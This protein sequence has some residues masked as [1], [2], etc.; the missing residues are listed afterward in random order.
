MSE[1]AIYTDGSCIPTNPGPGGWAAILV[2][3]EQTKELTGCTPGPTTNQRMEL[4]A[5][6]EALRALNRPC[7]ISVFTDSQYV[8]KGMTE[9]LPG[10]KS[11]GRLKSGAL[12]NSDLWIQ[13][14]E[15][16]TGHQAEWVWVKG[17]AGNA[18]NTKVDL[19]AHAAARRARDEITDRMPT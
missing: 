2:F 10:W 1:V 17:H 5:V 19:L 18:M 13:L 9:W 3:G 7:R 11:Q 14:D 4:T 12:T 16:A 8:Q 6:I 15:L